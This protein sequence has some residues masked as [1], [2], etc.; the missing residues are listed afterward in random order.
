M[1]PDE[2][3]PAGAGP[4]VNRA[5]E[6]RRRLLWVAGLAALV[7]GLTIVGIHRASPRSFVSA[8]GMLHAAVAYRFD[9]PLSI[10]AVPPENPFFAGEALPYYWFFHY[11]AARVIDLLPIHAFQAFEL[12]VLGAIAL[13]WFSG[14]LAG[15]GLHG[16]VLPGFA[17]GLFTFAGANPFG[18]GFLAARFTL[19]GTEVFAD[20][21]NYLWG[22]VHPLIREARFEDPFVLYG[23]LVNFFVNVT[24]RPLALA[25]L[26][27]SVFALLGYLRRGGGGRL[28]IL[29]IGAALCTAFSPIVGLSVFPVCALAL[30]LSRLIPPGTGSDGGRRTGSAGP[31]AVDTGH[32]DEADERRWIL[33]AVALMAGVAVALPTYWHLLGLTGDGAT[34]IEP[35]FRVIRAT[36]ASAGLLC[37]L[38]LAATLRASGFRRRF[39]AALL[40][41]GLVLIAASILLRLP[42]GNEANFF[43]AA[44]VLVGVPAAGV[45][46]PDLGWSARR[47]WIPA[48]ALVL[49]FVPTPLVVLASYLGRPAVPLALE[50]SSVR[51][52]PET[53]PW[54]RVY[55]WIREE[56]DEDAVFVTDPRRPLVTA[57]GNFPELP[58]LT[59]RFLFTTHGVNYVVSPNA[60]AD[61]RERIATTLVDGERLD[62]DD[63]RYLDGFDRRVYLIRELAAGDEPAAPREEAPGPI[64]FRADRLHVYALR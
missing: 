21:P 4:R 37:V 48:A 6:G 64:A 23:P 5:E 45:F 56:T 18:A 58:A 47:R 3:A 61:I 12:L 51:R 11:A 30:G 24:S 44:T 19:H 54:A 41:T 57:V 20:D 25:V 43:H 32:G 15:R 42:V 60:D 49:V 27:F 62:P 39:M 50:G 59:G 13:V 28:A 63:E 36:A 55:R 17:V 1:S 38:A 52:V 7:T 16:G 22:L 10:V 34:T 26:V 46:S 40:A 53:D 8:H 2:H 31:K 35:S 14:G 9:S 29:V 33:A